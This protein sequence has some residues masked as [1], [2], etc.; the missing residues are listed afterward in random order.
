M[1]YL[2]FF[3]T[4][5][6]SESQSNA[7]LYCFYDIKSVKEKFLEP[8]F[9]TS[10]TFAGRLHL[11][12]QPNNSD[13]D[14]ESNEIYNIQYDEFNKIPHKSREDVDYPHELFNLEKYKGEKHF[15]YGILSWGLTNGDIAVNMYQHPYNSFHRALY[16]FFYET[17]NNSVYGYSEYSKDNAITKWTTLLEQVESRPATNPFPKPTRSYVSY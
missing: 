3:I 9:I 14:I 13:T 11:K 12:N 7:K 1:Q 4:N 10:I 8:G 6:W 17:K 2:L 5:C 15:W 16:E